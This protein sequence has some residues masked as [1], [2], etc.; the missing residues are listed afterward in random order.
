MKFPVIDEIATR[1]VVSI[2]EAATL[3]EAVDRMV[4]ADKRDIIVEGTHGGFGILTVNDVIRLRANHTDLAT[5]LSEIHYHGIPQAVSGTNLLDVF[6]YFAGEEGYLCITDDGGHLTGILS[7][8]DII[9]SIDP[10]VMIER[11]RVGDI[12]LKNVI[13][14]A[15]LETPLGEVFALLSN[16]SDAVVLCDDGKPRGVLT[17]KDAIRLIRGHV[18]FEAPAGRFMSSPLE[19]VDHDITVKEAIDYIRDRKFK[20]I[21][22]KGG[23]ERLVGIIHQR[24]LIDIAYSKWSEMLRDQADELRDM[25]SVLERR[26]VSLEKL[27]VTDRLTGAY[28]RGKFERA[29]RDEISRCFR[30]D[31]C[32]FCIALMDLDHFKRV[33]DRFGHLAGDEVLKGFS[34]LVKS[35]IRDIDL[36]ARWG[37][38]EF[39]LLLP[40]TDLDGAELLTD[41]LREAVAEYEFPEVGQVTVSIGV[42]EHQHEEQADPLMNRA[43]VALYRAKEQGR[44]RV[45]S[46]RVDKRPETTAKS[47]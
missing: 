8:T 30:Y 7:Y 37:G 39:I 1:K 14:H 15:P 40:G 11:Q 16:V 9:T 35:R 20:R 6:Q 33:N 47:E 24:E 29:L 5:P 26:A 34:A 17:T 25:V 13:K 3:G 41:R 36:F 44:N 31:A 32:P 4:S 21:V 43:D 45:E 28:N 46:S 2:P 42:A 27:A 23:D 18:D 12:L 22:V 10:Q 19:T 38:E